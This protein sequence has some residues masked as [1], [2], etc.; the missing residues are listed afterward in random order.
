MDKLTDIQNTFQLFADVFDVPNGCLVTQRVSPSLSGASKRKSRPVK[1]IITEEEED[2]VTATTAAV[3]AAIGEEEVIPEEEPPLEPEDEPVEE[4]EAIP[5]EGIKCPAMQVEASEPLLASLQQF[6]NNS[7]MME[8][9]SQDDEGNTS[10]E[11]F[12]NGNGDEMEAG[13]AGTEFLRKMADMIQGSQSNGSLNSNFLQQQL[14][15]LKE[16]VDSPSVSTNGNGLLTPIQTQ[17]SPIF[18]S[19]DSLNTPEKLLQAIMTPS[20]GFLGTNGLGA[21]NNGLLSSPLIA[22]SPTL[23]QSLMNTPTQP[24]ASLTPKKVEN[25][26]PVVSQTLKASKR[27]LFDDT[28]RIEAATMIG[29]DRIDMNELEAFAQLFKKQRIKF[30]FTQGDVGV[31]LGKRYGTDFS[32]TTISRFEAL[33]L[34]FKNMCKLRPLLKEWLADVEMAIEGG[35]TVTDLIDKKT[36]HNGNH[37]PIPHSEPHESITTTMASI[38]ASSFLRSEQHVKR[39]RKRTNLDMNQ[40][41]ALDTFFSLNPRPDHDKMTDIANSLEL[42]RDVVR[43]WFCNRRQ[44]MRRVDDPLEGEIVTP[45]VSPVFPNISTMSALEEIQE[46]ARLASCQTSNEDSDGTSGSPEAPSNDGDL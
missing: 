39:R 10:D 19:N 27:R 16:T 3:I 29:D 30:G 2:E 28:S 43:V 8:N 31:A 25:R 34:S 17:L 44:K 22:P 38:N 32:Q 15:S 7:E 26:P 4:E 21:S 46:A 20:L 12:S 6:I 5:P 41:N 13:F 18:T 9:G 23:L 45:S 37:H 24:P 11:V 36:I 35:A 40:R 14:A 33:N 1:R 42:D